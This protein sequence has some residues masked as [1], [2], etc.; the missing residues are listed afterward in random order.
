[1]CKAHSIKVGKTKSYEKFVERVSQINQADE[2]GGCRGDGKVTWCCHGM[3]AESQAVC[4]ELADWDSMCIYKKGSAK[5]IS[6]QEKCQTVEEGKPQ[7]QH[8]DFNVY[9]N[10]Q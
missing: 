2:P 10:Y 1:M 6:K 8:L 9:A 4:T 3:S 7:Q 5:K